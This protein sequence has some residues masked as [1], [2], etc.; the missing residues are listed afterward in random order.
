MEV[1]SKRIHS[2][3]KKGKMR[4]N[5]PVS[6]IEL[7][8]LIP[9]RRQWHPTPVLLPGKSHGQRSLGGCSPWG[10]KES[11]TTE[12]L[13]SLTHSLTPPKEIST[14]DCDLIWKW[15]LYRF[16][17]LRSDHEGGTYSNMTDILVKRG[18]RG[19]DMHRKKVWRHR[20]CAMWR[21]ERLEFRCRKPRNPKS[22]WS[23]PQARAAVSSTDLRGAWPSQQLGLGHLA[24]GTVKQ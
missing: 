23:P 20:E 24:S 4:G 9:W 21:Q 6:W 3:S 12:Q 22:G 5:L 10:C 13:H 18:N 17:N 1:K 2:S 15:G 14:S 7:C 11:D 8:T 19:T 16:N